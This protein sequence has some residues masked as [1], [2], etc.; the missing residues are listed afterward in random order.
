MKRRRIH[1]GIIGAVITVGPLLGFTVHPAFH[2]LAVAFGLT[3]LQSAFTG[4]CPLYF[5]LEKIGVSDS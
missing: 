1:D 2:L 3:M 5:T 4:F